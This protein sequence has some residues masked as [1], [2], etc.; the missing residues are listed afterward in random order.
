MSFAAAAGLWL[1]LISL[2]IVVLYV[3]KIKRHRRTVPYL[4]LWAD[5][6]DDRQFTTLFQRLQRLLSLLLQLL[7][8]LCI[9][10]AFASLTPMAFVMVYGVL[11]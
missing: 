4:K 3:L 1:G 2:P 10:F 6:V 11:V 9:V 7:I 5:L 8:A